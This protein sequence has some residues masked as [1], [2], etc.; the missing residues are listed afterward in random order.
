[1]FEND[2]FVIYSEDNAEQLI[3]RCRPLRAE[4][5]DEDG[6]E[7]EEDVFLKQLE[8][9]MLDNIT[10][11]GITGIRRVFMVEKPQAVIRADTGELDRQDEWMLETDGI[12]LE[13][14]L[15][16]EGVDPVR[17]YSNNC[18]EILRTLGIEAARASLLRELRA[19]IEFDGSYV[20][21]RHLALLC[22]LM[23]NRGK[24]MA[25]TR[26]GINRA[27][28]SALMRCT[29]EETVEILMEAAAVGATDECSGVAEN[30]LL[31]QLAPMG[32]GAFELSLDLDMLKDVV[33]DHRLPMMGVD[34]NGLPG[35]MT[36]APGGGMTPYLEG[37]QTVMAPGFDDLAAA[38]FSPVRCFGQVQPGAVAHVCAIASC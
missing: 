31:G 27:E 8:T 7:V 35:G 4:N 32:T 28:T 33:I 11:G 23:T 18:V 5:E 9:A 38:A 22:D 1:V 2:L 20:N 21:Y 12:N 34:P 26:H 14:V 19:V 16:T 36:P 3:I 25:I 13:R 37:G 17:T 29:F 10:L 15:C 30:I 24:L 6:D